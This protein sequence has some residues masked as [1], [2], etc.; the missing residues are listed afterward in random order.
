MK[1][2]DI[3]EP[4]TSASV[5]PKQLS[6]Y[7]KSKSMDTSRRLV[8]SLGITSLRSMKNDLQ[9]EGDQTQ[10][11]ELQ[12]LQK[13]Q[14][15]VSRFRSYRKA[16]LQKMKKPGFSVREKPFT[17]LPRA[18][19][20]RTT[21]PVTDSKTVPATP[22]I[23]E[24]GYVPKTKSLV[25]APK[26]MTA[27]STM[28]VKGS[29]GIVRRNTRRGAR[30]GMNV[31]PK[32]MK[33]MTSGTRSV[34]KSV[35]NVFKSVGKPFTMI[36]GLF[37]VLLF[38]ILAIVLALAGLVN[39]YFGWFIHMFDA[40]PIMQ[41]GIGD[42]SNAPIVT[43]ILSRIDSE[44]LQ[45]AKVYVD[46]NL[47]PDGEELEVQYNI[48]TKNWD[49]CLAVTS[50]IADRRGVSVWDD[51]G[52]MYLARE[53]HSAMNVLYL[54]K[55]SKTRTEL[56]PNSTADPPETIEKIVH[57]Y[58]VLQDCKDLAFAESHFD[59][60]LRDLQL[61]AWLTESSYY[62]NYFDNRR[63]LSGAM[64][65]TSSDMREILEQIPE[66]LQREM[67]RSAMNRLGWFYVLGADSNAI[68]YADCSSLVQAA[69]REN[70]ISVPRDSRQQAYYFLQNGMTISRTYLRPGD[71]VYYSRSTN[72]RETSSYYHAAVYVGNVNGVD[73]I[74]DASSSIGRVVYRP[75]WGHPILFARLQD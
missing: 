61:I 30:K 24:K 37:I 75:L 50:I 65:V 34:I 48:E 26:Q 32:L 41:Y 12:V 72:I 4:R 36:G 17:E 74:I 57:Q 28:K 14:E 70:G 53:V 59:L 9:K 43:V 45:S 51:V 39:Q 63:E 44:F 47:P 8:S 11:M 1:G 29:S 62:Q 49:L 66:G 6:I 10:H 35:E 33:K 67:V 68:G 58:T 40:N 42:V 52:I 31:K 23:K 38:L 20:P 18:N 73:M 21:I 71:L 25:V 69:A 55:D 56:L 16:V 46:A 2:G 64:N 54:N 60:S 22:I 19:V 5:P 27:N 7:A 15:A 3:L 13:P